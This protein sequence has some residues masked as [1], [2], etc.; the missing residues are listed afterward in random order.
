[1]ELDARESAALDRRDDR[2]VVLG[3]GDGDRLLR[4]AGIGVREVHV[5]PFESGEKRGL[6]KRPELVPPHVRDAPRA[7]AAHGPPQE[8]ETLPAL[9]ALLEEKLHAHADAEHRPAGF[10]PLSQR[11]CQAAL[12]EHPRGGAEMSDPGDD[13]ERCL[14]D[15]GCV[16]RYLRLRARALQCRADAAHVARTVVGQYNPHAA[17]FVERT[18]PPSR[19]HAS[20]SARPS[21]LNAASA[22]WWSSAPADST[23]SV[24]PPWSASRSSA[25]GSRVR[26]RPPTRSPRNASATSAC[27]RRTRSTAALACASSIGSVAEPKRA[28]PSRRPSAWSRASPRP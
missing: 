25:C 11:L 12:F 18:P 16:A 7:H 22:M 2:A 26:A 14:A 23:C 27:G 4:V 15:S 20:P 9:L 24:K 10:S 6:P 19:A 21:A 28:R 17:P 13:R 3:L 8:A 1:M 5:G